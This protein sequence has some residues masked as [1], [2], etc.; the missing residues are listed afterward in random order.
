[1]AEA[2]LA[3]WTGVADMV[4]SVL[5][6]CH[7]VGELNDVMWPRHGLPCG[8]PSLAYCFKKI[9]DS[10]GVDRVTSNVGELLEQGR[11]TNQPIIELTY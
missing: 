3:D 9:V 10:T 6:K 8:T 1:M 7:L 2:C 11:A 4:Q 5:G